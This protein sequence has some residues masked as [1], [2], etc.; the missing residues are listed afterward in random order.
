[1]RTA[2]SL[3]FAVVVASA[4]PALAQGT[5]DLTLREVETDVFA[6]LRAKDARIEEILA[7]VA[8]R[9]RKKLIGLERLERTDPITAELVERPLNQMLYTIA[10]CAGARVRV[11][12]NTI[13]ISP[14]LGGRATVEELEEQATIAFLRALQAAPDHP[15]GARAEFALGELHEKRGQLRAAVG[16][17]DLLARNY[18]QSDLVP[19]ALWRSGLVLVRL[20]DWKA[21]VAAFTR[22]ANI[23]VSHAYSASARLQL[24]RCLVHSGDARQSLLLLDALDTLYP[25]QDEHEE[26]Q[27]L[28]VRS[29]A[30]RDLGRH[31]DALR[32]LARADQMGTAPEFE[33]HATELRARAFEHFDRPAEAARSWLRHAQLVEGLRREDALVNAARL[34]QAAGDPIAVLMIERTASAEG[35][36][37]EHRVAPFADA[38]RAELGLAVPTS[39]SRLDSA[40]ERAR[41]W[42][43]AHLARQAVQTLE[44]LWHERLKFEEG[45]RARLARHYAQALEADLGLERG[46]ELLRLAAKDVHGAEARK[47]LTLTAG[48]LY[49]RNDRYEDAARAY[50]GDL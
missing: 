17:F 29:L 4:S 12:P 18:S 8:A 7:D 46:L 39:E 10:G 3:L 6:T 2:A 35:P 31:G 41:T 40:I 33:V 28:F 30:L 44:P 45:A 34:S 42:L 9:T 15:D 14:D 36:G 19:E 48:E 49:E 24:A 11:N 22:L 37:V 23:E 21:G 32:A 43:S 13:E 50:G 20:E 25:T 16:H 27:R 38:A 26:Q 47:L 1:M 5:Y